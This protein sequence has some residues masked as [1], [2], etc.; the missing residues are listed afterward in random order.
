MYINFTVFKEKDTKIIILG[1]IC[2]TQKTCI[3]FSFEII[4]AF[5]AFHPPPP[6]SF[7]NNITHLIPL[8]DLLIET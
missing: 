7:K 1:F 3:F 8:R 2:I 6:P 4:P 5:I